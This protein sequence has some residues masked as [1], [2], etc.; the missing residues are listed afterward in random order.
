MRARMLKQWL[1]IPLGEH[2]ACTQ[3]SS[4]RP[5]SFEYL[6][7]SDRHS[8]SSPSGKQLALRLTNTAAAGQDSEG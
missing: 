1:H 6:R 4:K 3:L 8:R 5:L 2:R 7:Y